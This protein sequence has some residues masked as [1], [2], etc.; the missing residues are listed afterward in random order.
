MKRIVFLIDFCIIAG[1]LA[2]LGGVILILMS[3]PERAFLYFDGVVM[4]L[5]GIGL[6]IFGVV[7][8]RAS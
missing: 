4:S 7:L 3:S 1:L 6:M 5:G 8:E 2:F